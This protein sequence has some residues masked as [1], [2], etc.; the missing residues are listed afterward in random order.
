MAWMVA[1]WNRTAVYHLSLGVDS[2]Y[3]LSPKAGFAVCEDII[4]KNV[5]FSKTTYPFGPVQI[6]YIFCS[7]LLDATG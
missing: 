6:I 5:L 7:K 3:L 4:Q 2:L 1:L